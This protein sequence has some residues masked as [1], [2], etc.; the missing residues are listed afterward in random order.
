MSGIGA[1]DERFRGRTPRVDAGS[2][3][4]LALNQGDAHARPGKAAGQRRPGL[5]R[6]NDNRVERLDHGND[7]T[8]RIAPPIA[9][10]SSRIAI[11]TSLPPVAATSLVRNS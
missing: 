8:I 2:P 6:S 10:A 11:G 5:P 9:I 1:G 3:N 4:E 7:V